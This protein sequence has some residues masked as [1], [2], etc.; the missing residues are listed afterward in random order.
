MAATA[1]MPYVNITLDVGT[2]LNAFKFLR[3]G[4][5]QY[6]NVQIHL[7]DFHFMKEIFQVLQKQLK[8]CI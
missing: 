3:N 1:N 4:M 8:S 2:A 6:E 5:Q 7:R